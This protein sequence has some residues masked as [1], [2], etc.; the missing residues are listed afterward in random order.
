VFP[1]I[2]LGVNHQYLTLYF[3]RVDQHRKG[4]PSARSA[5]IDAVGPPAVGA[6]A[7]ARCAPLRAVCAPRA[8]SFPPPARRAE[9]P[10][11]PAPARLLGD[12]RS[13]SSS[14]A[15]AT[16][17]ALTRLPFGFS[18]GSAKVFSSAKPTFERKKNK[19]KQVGVLRVQHT[20][21]PGTI[22]GE[23]P[24]LARLSLLT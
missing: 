9:R 13:R 5:R 7:A 15:G 14:S 1:R 22:K 4:D 23:L 17:A 24:S 21:R 19:R 12:S 3:R 16:R 18:T 6:W 2:R 8:V 10:V 20:V 11:P